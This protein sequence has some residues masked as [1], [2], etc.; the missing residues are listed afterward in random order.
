[1]I[2]LDVVGP[3]LPPDEAQHPALREYLPRRAY[4]Q[5]HRVA[6]PAGRQT[7]LAMKVVGVGIAQPGSDC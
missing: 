4:G 3:T 5:V 6:D 7:H 1:M 2:G